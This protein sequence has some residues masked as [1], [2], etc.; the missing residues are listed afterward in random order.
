M[1]NMKIEPKLVKSL[2]NHQ[3]CD[4]LSKW[5]FL[6]MSQG[7]FQKAD[8]PGCN[9]MTTRGVELDTIPFPPLA[10]IIQER[11]HDHFGLDNY[12]VKYPFYHNAMVASYGFTPDCCEAHKDPRYYEGFT[13]FHCLSLLSQPEKGG[14]P[15]I[16][17]IEYPMDKGDVL[18]VPVSECEHGTT[19]LEGN[20]PRLLWIFGFSVKV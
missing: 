4:S 13:T 8:H 15:V 7:Y 14:T 5:I 16:D 20:T 12:E 10:F 19:L 6:N 1:Q 2:I 17:G 18:W 11:I 9:R 3:E